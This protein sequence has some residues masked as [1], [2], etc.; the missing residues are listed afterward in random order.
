MMKKKGLFKKRHE[1]EDMSLQ[2]TSLADIF[3]ILLVFLLKS[4]ATSAVNLTP[5]KGL[6]MPEAHAAEAAIDAL[7]VE[8]SESAVQVEGN[9]VTS[10]TG[11]KFGAGDLKPNGTSTTLSKA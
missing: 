10:L 11:F 5:S 8:I 3:V 2:I 1:S 4:Y 7:K 9:A 6:V